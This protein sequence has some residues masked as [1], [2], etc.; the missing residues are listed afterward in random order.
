MAKHISKPYQDQKERLQ[1]VYARETLAH[2]A[3]IYAVK[4]TG[5][6]C[7]PTCPSRRPKPENLELFDSSADA[8]KAGFRPCKRCKPDEFIPINLDERVKQACRLLEESG[9]PVSL[10]ELAAKV[11]LSPSHLHRLF[12]KSLSLTPKQ[13]ADGLRLGRLQSGLQKGRPVSEALYAAGYGSS[14]RVYEKSDQ[15]LGMT[16]GQYQGR[17]A[18]ARIKYALAQTSLGWLLVA[19]T[20][21]GVCFIALGDSPQ[22]LLDS[23]QSRF[24]RADISQ[25]DAE[26][27]GL[28]K[29]LTAFLDAPEQ[30]LDLPLDIQGTAFQRRVWAALQELKPGQTI[31]YSQMAQR[32]GMPQAPRA[33]ASA[34]ASNPLALAVPCHR[35][36]RKD[37]GLGGYRWG[38]ARKEQLLKRESE[39]SDSTQ[40][41]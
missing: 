36:V 24:S 34:I 6:Y 15:L 14:S 39:S 8:Q 5:V 19:A 35:V 16:P 7:R 11:N 3:F 20:E 18:K 28:L 26:F 17:G 33:V 9:Q 23:L 21:K 30:G 32:L 40:S 10:A 2:N 1:A 38:L 4:T 25:A 41:D 31:T 12:K 37:G 22:K 29:H 13:Y 27:S